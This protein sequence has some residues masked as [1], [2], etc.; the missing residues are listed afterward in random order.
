MIFLMGI[1]ILIFPHVLEFLYIYNYNNR[2]QILV[3][4]RLGIPSVD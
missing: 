3:L 4:L 2:G 1:T